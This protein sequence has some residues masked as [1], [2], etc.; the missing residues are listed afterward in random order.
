ME[1]LKKTGRMEKNCGDAGE[2]G[3]TR[4]NERRDN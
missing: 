2:K 4:G 3:E 1:T